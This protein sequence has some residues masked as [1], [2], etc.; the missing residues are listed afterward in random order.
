MEPQPFSDNSAYFF[1]LQHCNLFVFAIHLVHC[2]SLLFLLNYTKCNSYF[3]SIICLCHMPKACEFLLVGHHFK[4]TVFV[5][6]NIDFVFFL[7]QRFFSLT[8]SPPITTRKKYP[9]SSSACPGLSLCSS[10]QENKT[11]NTFIFSPLRSLSMLAWHCLLLIFNVNSDFFS[12]FCFHKIHLLS[13]HFQ[14]I[15]CCLLHSSNC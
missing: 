4:G 1:H 3:Q 2:L 9:Y 15:K 8:L 10:P 6:L 13:L 11:I 7:I 12:H 14:L 5:W